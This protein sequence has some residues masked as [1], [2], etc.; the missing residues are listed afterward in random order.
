MDLL[1][2]ASSE[3]EIRT[4]SSLERWYKCTFHVRLGSRFGSGTLALTEGNRSTTRRRRE[5]LFYS[6]LKHSPTLCAEMPFAFSPAMWKGMASTSAK[7]I[8]DSS[9]VCFRKHLLFSLNHSA[10]SH[11][12]SSAQWPG[13]NTLCCCPSA[14]S[15]QESSESLGS[16]SSGSLLFHVISV[17]M[18]KP[19]ALPERGIFMQVLRM[20][21]MA[22]SRFELHWPQV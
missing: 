3:E 15:R 4:V 19:T 17:H 20:L 5:Y 6:R 11:R 16:F 12:A 18:L 21:Y 14:Y 22:S 1:A 2:V 10:R 7:I 13:S 9:A 8:Y